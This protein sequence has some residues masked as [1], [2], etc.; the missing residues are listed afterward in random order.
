ML[1]LA[2]TLANSMPISLTPLELEHIYVRGATCNPVTL[3]QLQKRKRQPQ[4]GGKTFVTAIY[5]SFR[6]AQGRE[7][8]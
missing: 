6:V 3:E 4:E 1:L 8:R 5:L 7:I 2:T